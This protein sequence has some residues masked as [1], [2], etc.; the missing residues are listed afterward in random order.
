[1]REL[2][3]K[4]KLYF[5]VLIPGLMFYAYYLYKILSFPFEWEP[6]DG[7]H[8]NFVNRIKEGLPIFYDLQSG[9]IL[10]VYNPLY[11]Y[12]LAYAELDLNPFVLAR[13]LSAFFWILSPVLIY[14]YLARC[15]SRSNSLLASIAV[16]FPIQSGLL[17]DMVQITPA[18]MMVLLFVST[19]LIADSIGIIGKS[20]WKVVLV[21]VLSSL[22]FLAKQ[23]GIIVL[24]V[25]LAYFL[26]AK[27]PLKKILLFLLVALTTY[28]LAY[29]CVTL[30][31]GN[32]LIPSTIT[33]VPQIIKTYWKLS[34]IRFMLFAGFNALLISL[35]LYSVIQNCVRKKLNIW[36]VSFILHIP[37]LLYILKNGAGGSNYFTTFWISIVVVSFKLI[38]DG[39]TDF[40][41]VEKIGK[42]VFNL[43][44]FI[45][46]LL[47]PKLIYVF[48]FGMLLVGQT[49]FI[50]D[51]SKMNLPDQELIEIMQNA[52]ASSASLIQDQE[53]LNILTNRN[54]GVFIDRKII[55]NNEGCSLF[56]AWKNLEN[57]EKSILLNKISNQD[58]D[59]I[60]TGLQPYPQDLQ[61]FIDKYYVVVDSYP[62]NLLFGYVGTQ[63]IFAP[64]TA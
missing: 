3:H 28:Y 8:L 25:L 38:F 54:I 31:D 61:I 34:I 37:F 60:T 35:C 22:A 1:M 46:K 15:I 33:E 12:L 17:V 23:Q 19:V 64:K 42:W 51:V 57:F 63:S 20:T 45:C 18:A 16:L 7:D 53:G 56:G 59:F 41:R 55:I 36:E 26:V 47:A 32:S 21:G 43:P 29:F 62:T 39:N 11:H 4:R 10:S 58:F 27:F 52:S 6:T 5:A 40:Q 13:L 14:F 2:I 50:R 24:I 48:L 44:T 49:I 9:N 30:V